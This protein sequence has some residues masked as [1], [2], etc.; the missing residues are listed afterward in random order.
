M[1][2]INKLLPIGS[3]VLLKAGV[4]K[5]MII[6]IKQIKTDENDKEFD[7]IGVLYPEGFLGNETNFLFNHD[8]INDIIFTGYSNPERAEFLAFIDEAYKKLENKE[9]SDTEKKD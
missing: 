2:E 7:Y 6:G 4:K 3:V 9:E 5:L 1:I 8:D